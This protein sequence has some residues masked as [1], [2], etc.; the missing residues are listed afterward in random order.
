MSKNKPIIAGAL[1]VAG[2]LA[3]SFA[4]PSCAHDSYIVVQMKAAA[5]TLVGVTQVRVDVT[6][7]TTRTLMVTRTFA[8]TMDGGLSIDAMDGKTFSLSFTPDHSGPV[9]LAVTASGPGGCMASGTQAAFPIKKGGTTMATVTLSGT[10]GALPDGGTPDGKVTFSGCAPATPGS[11]PAQQTCYVDCTAQMGTCTPAGTRGA[12][13]ACD[14]NMDCKPGTQCFDYACSPKASTK[15]CLKFC[16]G[17]ADCAG[18]TTV[19]AASACTDPVVCPP[20]TTY[21]TCGFACDPRGD[22]KKGCPVGLTCFLFSSPTG[23]QDAPGC[24][25]SADTRVG[26]DGARCV[27]ATDCAPGFLCDQMAGGTFCR[28][29]CQMASPGDCPTGQSCAAL[30]NNSTYGVCLPTPGG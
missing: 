24:G 21:K 16:N 26:T 14:T 29:L 11:C 13:E 8:I 7:V 25:C 4:T 12:G 19:S 6:D 1:L 10:C 3:L 23:G 18:S 22:G 30:Q 2:A 5:G 9:D 15:Y 17:D 20:T 27:T 28:R